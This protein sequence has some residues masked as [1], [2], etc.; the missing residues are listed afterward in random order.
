MRRDVVL[1]RKWKTKTTRKL[2]DNGDTKT[3]DGVGDTGAVNGTRQG[4]DVM[5]SRYTLRFDKP[6]GKKDGGERE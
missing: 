1:L 3:K 2:S 4:K 5:Q 6:S